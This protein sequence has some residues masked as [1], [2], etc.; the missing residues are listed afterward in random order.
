MSRVK[1][2]FILSLL[3]IIFAIY[4]ILEKW[5]LAQALSL[6]EW[7]D[8]LAGFS[9]PLAFFWLVIGYFQQGEELKQN[10]EALKQQEAALQLQVKELKRSVEQQKELVEAQKQDVKFAMESSEREHLREK[11]RSQPIFKAHGGGVKARNGRQEH[12]L[13]IINKGETIKRV[14]FSIDHSFKS[15]EFRAPEID[16]WGADEAQTLT[17]LLP[18]EFRTNKTTSFRVSVCF[19]DGLDE[20]EETVLY[21]YSNKSGHFTLSTVERLPDYD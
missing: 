20:Q 14:S 10:T 17:L 16:C 21:Y 8:F 1:L 7:G 18:E 3:W 11:A 15:H 2:G 9:A 12:Q 4:L 19:L 13:K 5:D 6:N